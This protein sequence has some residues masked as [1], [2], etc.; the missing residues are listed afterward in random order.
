[1]QITAT[2]LPIRS[3]GVQGKSLRNT[4]RRYRVNELTRLRKKK[5]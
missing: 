5:R 3:V 4:A 1:M 2:V